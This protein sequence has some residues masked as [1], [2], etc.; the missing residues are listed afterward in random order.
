MYPT[1]YFVQGMAGGVDPFVPNPAPWSA[2]RISDYGYTKMHVMNHTHLKVEQ[3]SAVKVGTVT[4]VSLLFYPELFEGG[5]GGRQLYND[6]KHAWKVFER[7]VV[8]LE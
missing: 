1:K 6:Q 8:V 2:V 3:V 4:R 7:R 5:K